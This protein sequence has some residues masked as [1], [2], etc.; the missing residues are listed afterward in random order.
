[1]PKLVDWIACWPDME[2]AFAL[3]IPFFTTVSNATPAPT[4]AGALKPPTSSEREPAK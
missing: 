3:E 1:M 4:A 2:A